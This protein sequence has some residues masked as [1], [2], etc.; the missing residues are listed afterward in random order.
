MH[1][2]K[3]EKALTEERQTGEALLQQR[4][5][6]SKR[7][8]SFYENQ[9]VTELNDD[10][11]T[12][13]QAQDIV[14]VATADAQGK[15]DSSIRVGTPG[16]VFTLDKHTLVYPEYR[17]NGVYASLGNIEENAHIGLLFVDFATHGIGL[18]VN[19]SARILERAQMFTWSSPSDTTAPHPCDDP[20]AER[21]VVISVEE[22]FIHCSKHIPLMQKM[23]RDIEWGTDNEEK[24]GGDFFNVRRSK[25]SRRTE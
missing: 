6:S 16:F 14:F 22:A 12:F 13:I 3:E 20:L 18:H 1:E 2:W 8:L 17:G 25:W 4:Y 11:M 10:M 9:V 15:C 24:K 23:D 19:G 21:F 5:G 7:A